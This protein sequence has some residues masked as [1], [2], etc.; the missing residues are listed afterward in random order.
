LSLA[1]ELGI[2][3]SARAKLRIAKIDEQDEIEQ[4]LDQQR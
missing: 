1:K 2:T 4:F 3:P